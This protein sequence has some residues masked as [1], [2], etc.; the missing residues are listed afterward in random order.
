[1]IVRLI[2]QFKKDFS[3]PSHRRIL[4]FSLKLSNRYFVAT[5]QVVLVD[6]QGACV[7]NPI[8][9]KEVLE[10]CKF[11]GCRLVRMVEKFSVAG[12]RNSAVVSG[13]KIG[14]NVLRI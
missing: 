8:C 10:E 14:G 9:I 4:T 6:L 3:V 12:N 13:I 1:M 5:I 11:V 2:A 7:D